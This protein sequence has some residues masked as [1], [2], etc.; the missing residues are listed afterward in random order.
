MWTEKEKERISS[1]LSYWIHEFA[2]P[3][4]IIDI[5]FSDECEP[6]VDGFGE[7]C[8]RVDSDYPYRQFKITVL[9][10]ASGIKNHRLHLAAIHEILHLAL[11]RLRAN[12]KSSEHTWRLLEEEAVDLIAHVM[13]NNKKRM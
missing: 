7:N 5:Q 13:N 2:L 10:P 1:V 11:V 9:P 3:P 6:T 4:A 8:M 12:R